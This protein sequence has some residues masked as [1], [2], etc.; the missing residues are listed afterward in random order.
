LVVS[1]LSYIPDAIG[2]EDLSQSE[3]NL[4]VHA[5][6]VNAI[7]SDEV[8]VLSEVQNASRVGNVGTVCSSNEGKV[9]II[10]LVE[11]EPD[12]RILRNYHIVQSVWTNIVFFK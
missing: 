3:D 6:N 2:L 5:L 9:N 10:P 7:L 8:V 11:P 12:N 1:A 4:I